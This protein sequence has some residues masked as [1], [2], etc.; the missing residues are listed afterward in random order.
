MGKPARENLK[1]I[2][3]DGLEA[4]LKSRTGER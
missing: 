3:S 1:T 4:W 2:L